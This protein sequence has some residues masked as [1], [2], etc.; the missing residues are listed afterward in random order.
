MSK[1]GC[2]SSSPSR[3]IYQCLTANYMDL[4]APGTTLTILDEDDETILRGYHAPIGSYRLAC[5]ERGKPDTV[6]RDLTYSACGS[7]CGSSARR[8]AASA[9]S[10]VRRRTSYDQPVD[11]VHVIEPNE[12]HARAAAAAAEE[13]PLLLVR[14]SGRQRRAARPPATDQ[15]PAASSTSSCGRAGSPSS[16]RSRRGG[17]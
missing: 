1:S 11:V 6:F 16:A 15:R 17:W 14:E 4:L 8:I 5:S 3:I 12:D 7:W 10:D 2:G 13:V 9:C